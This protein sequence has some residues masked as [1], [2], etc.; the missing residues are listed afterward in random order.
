MAIQ[1]T[2]KEGATPREIIDT[3]TK[4]CATKPDLMD[5]PVVID[6]P[7]IDAQEG[8]EFFGIGLVEVI[9]GQI[10]FEA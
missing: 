2:F 5:K 6:R 10:T 7:I 9:G 4:M 1:F 8:G 3:L